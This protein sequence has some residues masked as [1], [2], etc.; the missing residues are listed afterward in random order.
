MPGPL[1]EDK[2]MSVVSPG[3]SGGPNRGEPPRL[4]LRWAVIIGASAAAGIACFADGGIA[5]AVAAAVA[6]AG[7]LDQLLT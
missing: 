2:C 1:R 6:V 7:A 4:P 3:S 5:T